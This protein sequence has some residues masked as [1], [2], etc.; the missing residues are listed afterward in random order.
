[1]TVNSHLIHP[2][3]PAENAHKSLKNAM[4]RRAVAF[5]NS[6]AIAMGMLRISFQFLEDDVHLKLEGRLADQWADELHRL[7][8]RTLAGQGKNA[9]LEVNLDDVT[10]VDG[11]GEEVLK[12][13]SRIGAHFLADSASS[14]WLCDRIGLVYESTVKS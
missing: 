2:F 10:F 13:L 1:M 6:T 4:P 9:R 7:V 14:Q 5:G 8:V 11:C 12:W 3:L